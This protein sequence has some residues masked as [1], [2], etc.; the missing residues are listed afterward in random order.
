M[1]D[2][3][4][5]CFLGILFTYIILLVLILMGDCDLYLQ[6]ASKF[7]K[8]PSKHFKFLKQICHRTIIFFVYIGVLT[9]LIPS[10]QPHRINIKGRCIKSERNAKLLAYVDCCYK[11][12][13]KCTNLFRCIERKS[14]L[15]YR[16][17]EW[18]W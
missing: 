5:Y 3:L 12:L 8:K 14:C 1:L 9:Y 10:T 13:M 11:H 4:F 7:G 18:N 16:G 17:F 15:D 6:F 2:F